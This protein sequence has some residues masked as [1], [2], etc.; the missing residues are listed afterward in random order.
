M[1]E[2]QIRSP[3]ANTLKIGCHFQGFNSFP[4]ETMKLGVNVSVCTLIN[5]CKWALWVLRPALLC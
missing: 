3:A 4:A 5:A 1:Q 2:R